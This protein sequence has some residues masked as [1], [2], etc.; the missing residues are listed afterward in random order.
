MM[1]AFYPM[2]S[3]NQITEYYM[4]NSLQML[5]CDTARLLIFI[6]YTWL[7]IV[8]TILLGVQSIKTFLY[9]TILATLA[10]KLVKHS[11]ASC[12]HQVVL[13]EH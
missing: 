9:L 5:I 11:P 3:L 12:H 13:K 4:A 2:D 6:L 8:F 10:T 1:M 7:Y